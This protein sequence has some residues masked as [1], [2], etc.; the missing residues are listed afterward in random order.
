M[1]ILAIYTSPAHNFYGHHGKPAGREPVESRDVVTCVAGKGIEGDRFF[2][3]K[4]SYK[5][6]ITFFAQEVHEA[7][8]THFQRPDLP[9][10]VY[11]RNVVT[12]GLDLAA[13]IGREF[14]LG[15]IRFEGTQECA[16]CYWMNDA[17]GPGA[18]EFL[19]G[20]GGL[21]ARILS[22]GPLALGSVAL[23]LH[24]GSSPAARGG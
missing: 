23:Q 2:G 13:L 20:R 1:E 7:L 5:G 8:V 6:Q 14:S 19:K 10:S 4:E 24:A 15:G 3:Y 12:R 18:E 22:D 9:A 21:R 17:V 11:R 16:P